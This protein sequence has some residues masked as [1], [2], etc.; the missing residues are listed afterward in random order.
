MRGEG[1]GEERKKGAA[2]WAPCLSPLPPVPPSPPPPPRHVRILSRATFSLSDILFL[3]SKSL[4]LLL[5]FREGD[6]KGE[7]LAALL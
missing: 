5:N 4:L 7:E 1:R 6:R 3:S 2:A